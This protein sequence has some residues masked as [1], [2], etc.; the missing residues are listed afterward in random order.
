MD[1]K[2]RHT[3][4]MLNKLGELGLKEEGERGWVG[5]DGDKDTAACMMGNVGSRPFEAQG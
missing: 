5:G 4:S 1:C 2:T 3:E